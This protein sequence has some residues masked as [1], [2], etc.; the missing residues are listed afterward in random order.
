MT[1]IADERII[2]FGTLPPLPNGW[3]V[4]QLDSGHYIATNGSTESC[5]TVNKFHARKWAFQLAHNEAPGR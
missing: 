2:R 1:L 5:I 3:H 4:I